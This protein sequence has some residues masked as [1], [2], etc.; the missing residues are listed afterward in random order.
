M[1][2]KNSM[3]ISYELFNEIANLP[4]REIQLYGK[5][6]ES[7]Y[8]ITEHTSSEKRYI[9]TIHDNLVY[10]CVLI[11]GDNNHYIEHAE[12]HWEKYLSRVKGKEGSVSKIT[13]GENNEMQVSYRMLVDVVDV[14]NF[15]SEYT[16][17]ES[18]MDQYGSYISREDALT[19]TNIKLK[20][21]SINFLSSSYGDNT[22]YHSS[23]THWILK[24]KDDI[25]D[26]LLERSLEL[27]L[28]T[29]LQDKSKGEMV[30]SFN[31]INY[32]LMN[33]SYNDYRI[34]RDSDGSSNILFIW[35]DDERD[36]FI[37]KTATS[38]I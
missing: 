1:E 30:I 6:M 16:L 20:N 11:V 36:I 8:F 13:I 14:I 4:K 38:K 28:I 19:L 25:S 31:G 3:R 22:V 7:R 5:Y 12:Y 29:E 37:L 17:I 24:G 32:K 34:I 26:L 15:L 23:D 10:L 18:S 27:S 33:L 9:G 21:E 2:K 35:N